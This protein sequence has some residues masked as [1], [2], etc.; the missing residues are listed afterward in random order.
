MFGVMVGSQESHIVDL[1]PAA[2]LIAQKKGI[3]PHEGLES[4]ESS[5]CHGVQ[6]TVAFNVR[7]VSDNRSG[8]IRNSD[9]DYLTSGP[10]SQHMTYELKIHIHQHRSA[11]E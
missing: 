2:L 7:G 11:C 4:L 9:T 10:R 5:R 8:A 1:G 6:I 3:T